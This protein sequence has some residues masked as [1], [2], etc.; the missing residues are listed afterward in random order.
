MRINAHCHVFNLQAVFTQGTR[1]ILQNRIKNLPP[2]FPDLILWLLEEHMKGN[3]PADLRANALDPLGN[4]VEAVEQASA[5]KVTLPP[6]LAPL[7]KRGRTGDNGFW[8]LFDR[9]ACDAAF[10]DLG[11]LAAFSTLTPDMDGITDSFRP[12][13][14]GL[15]RRGRRFRHRPPDD[16]HPVHASGRDGT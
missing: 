7:L 2:P 16:G 8:S 1:N 6:L 4:L 10:C 12:D 13:R 11:D 9:A 15:R 5:G 14:P 3:P